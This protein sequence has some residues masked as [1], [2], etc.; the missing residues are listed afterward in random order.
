MFR[1][2]NNNTIKKAEHR[3]TDVF[4]LLEN[5]GVREDS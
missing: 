2:I 1:S 3:G 4:E 5:C